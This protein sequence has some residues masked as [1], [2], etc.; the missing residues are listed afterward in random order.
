VNLCLEEGG[1]RV[2]AIHAIFSVS[3]MSSFLLYIYFK[4]CDTACELSKRRCTIYLK[5]K[6][7]YRVYQLCDI[8]L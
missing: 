4:K 7:S 1:H 3:Q 6:G 8:E 2:H 5:L